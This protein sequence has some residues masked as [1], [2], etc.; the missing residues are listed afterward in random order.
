MEVCSWHITN[1]S[2][3][4]DLKSQMQDCNSREQLPFLKNMLCMIPCSEDKE[5]TRLLVVGEQ[6]D[7]DLAKGIPGRISTWLN[8]SSSHINN[9]DSKIGVLLGNKSPMHFS[10]NL[11]SIMEIDKDMCKDLA[12]ILGISMQQLDRI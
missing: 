3:T 9:E 5:A 6:T 1:G 2:N 11:E 4:H 10:I 12:F 7:K 8:G